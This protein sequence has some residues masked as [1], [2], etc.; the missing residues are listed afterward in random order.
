MMKKIRFAFIAFFLVII[1]LNGYSQKWMWATKIG[2]EGGGNDYGLAIAKDKRGNVMVTG[3]VKGASIFGTGTHAVTLQGFGDRDSYIA[4]YDSLGNLVWA[5]RYGGWSSDYGYGIAT[6]DNSNIYITGNIVGPAYFD[7]DTLDTNGGDIYVA[8]V[9]PS[10]DLIWA[11]SWGGNGDDY[12]SAIAVDKEGNAYITGNYIESIVFGTD[13]LLGKGGKDLFIAKI[14]ANGNPVWSRSVGDTGIEDS[15]TITINETGTSIYVAGSYQK[16][17]VFG[18]FVLTNY[19]GGDIFIAKYDINGQCLWATHA[20]SNQMEFADA[21]DLDKLGNLYVVGN[22]YNIL[23]FG[24]PANPVTLPYPSTGQDIF[25]AKYDTLGKI[26][27]VKPVG[28]GRGLNFGD[29]LDINKFNNPVICGFFAD[30]CYFGGQPHSI[31]GDSQDGFVA[32]YNDNG[33]ILWFKSYKGITK[34]GIFAGAHAV[35]TDNT[36]HTYLTGGFLDVVSFD[37]ISLT[38]AGVS[39]DVLVGKISPFLKAQINAS[40]K[41]ICLGEAIQ[42]TDIS[43]GFPVS[44]QWYLP[45]GNTTSP[46]IYNPLVTYDSAGIFDVALVI[47]NGVERDTIVLPGY[48]HVKD[49]TVDITKQENDQLTVSIGPSP[50]TDFTEVTVSGL[51]SSAEFKLFDIMGQC[52]RQVQMAD[53]QKTIIERENL[54]SGVYLYTIIENNSSVKGGKIIVQ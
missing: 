47:N 49:C 28:Y 3:R 41:E 24:T 48:I 14:D 53:K 25:L 54:S 37:T 8:K 9:S 33:E 12:A 16:T 43:R 13:T 18:S 7:K 15:R 34:N 51:K 35:L 20:G 30:T 2:L 4:K 17:A 45:G 29:G 1:S 52:V 27:W 31:E 40:L 5:R 10:G 11:K 46:T 50:F 32:E 22:Y 36:E 39:S 26:K 23:N 42:F 6:D 38:A 21:V 19:G 44:W